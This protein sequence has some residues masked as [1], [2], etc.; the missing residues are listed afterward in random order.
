[1]S[2]SEVKSRN[3]FM[4]VDVDFFEKP[5]NVEAVDRFGDVAPS[6][7]LR[8]LLRLMNEKDGRMKKT[9][10]YS[11]WRSSCNKKKLWIDII[12]YYLACQWLF[13]HDD[14]FYSLR[15]QKERER[16]EI[17]RRILSENAKQKLGKSTANA[18]QKLSK[19]T[20]TETDIRENGQKSDM[21]F[22]EVKQ[23]MVRVIK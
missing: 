2:R 16:V 8:V 12:N 10:V 11:M 3:D 19:S 17:K 4:I 13:E 6:A 23:K 15:I 9:Q 20:E 7:I 22:D 5:E 14:F 1:M 18:E 21:Y